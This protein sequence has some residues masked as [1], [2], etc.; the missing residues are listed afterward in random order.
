M[1][2]PENKDKI[3]EIL[4]GHNKKF[5]AV[6]LVVGIVVLLLIGCAIGYVIFELLTP[7]Q[8]TP[9]NIITKVQQ[10]PIPNA[11]ENKVVVN[12]NSKTQVTNNNKNPVENNKNIE[13]GTETSSTITMASNNTQ[14]KEENEQTGPKIIT[15]ESENSANNNNNNNLKNEKSK[16]TQSSI[17]V[18]TTTMKNTTHKKATKKYK[19][20]IVKK[21]STASNR[22]AY[23]H[24]RYIHPTR[25]I[26]QV[27][28]NKNRKLALLNVIKLRKCG[29]N[30]FTKEVKIKGTRYT[31]VYVGPIKGY[32]VAKQEAKE[33]KKQLHLKYFPLI[34]K[35]D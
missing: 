19:T 21:H 35:D 18:A 12:T 17:H 27:S 11:T 16:K 20:T 23:K 8:T 32:S 7:K 25:Y 5:T 28:S 24:H 15:P 10:P 1:A 31:R 33:I 29:H 4:E 34:K 3:K 14:N 13:N 2:G 26:I 22:V 30:A 6:E 9:N